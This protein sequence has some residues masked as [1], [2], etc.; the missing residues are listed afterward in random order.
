[1]I[2]IGIEVWADDESCRSGVKDLISIFNGAIVILVIRFQTS[3]KTSLCCD[4]PVV[5]KMINHNFRIAIKIILVILII[6][7]VI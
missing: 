3:Y 6:V 2:F 5:L 7:T 1:M 4:F